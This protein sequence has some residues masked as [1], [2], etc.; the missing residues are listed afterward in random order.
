MDYLTSVGGAHDNTIKLDNLPIEKE[1]ALE[2]EIEIVLDNPPSS[3][4]NN[5][6]VGEPKI[7]TS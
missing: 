4:G 7:P 3:V 5:S 1:A 6:G 2:G